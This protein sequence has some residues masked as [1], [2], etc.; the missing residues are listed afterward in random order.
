LAYED[1]MFDR[2]AAMLLKFAETED[3]DEK[4]TV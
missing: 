1:E 4:T 3:K 2:A